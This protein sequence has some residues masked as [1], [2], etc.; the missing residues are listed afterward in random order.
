MHIG[1]FFETTTK[2]LKNVLSLSCFKAN[3]HKAA[4]KVSDAVRL[5]DFNQLAKMKS[6]S[7]D[8]KLIASLYGT[9]LHSVYRLSNGDLETLRFFLDI[10]IDLNERDRSGDTILDTAVIEGRLDICRLLVT[11]GIKLQAS[12]NSG[13]TTPI[14]KAIR[15][16]Q[17]Q[18]LVYFLKYLSNHEHLRPILTDILKEALVDNRI[19]LINLILSY[20]LD[21]NRTYQNK[22]NLIHFVKSPY[23]FNKL[24]DKGFDLNQQDEFGVSFIAKLVTDNREELACAVLECDPKLEDSVSEFSDLLITAAKNNNIK[25]LEELIVK[26]PGAL[27]KLEEG[28][29]FNDW[30]ICNCVEDRCSLEVIKFFIDQ[31]ARIDG[32]T[33][34]QETPLM[35]AAQK[36]NPYYMRYLTKAGANPNLVDIEGKNALM[37]TII[38]Q[39]EKCIMPLLASTTNLFAKDKK[40]FDIILHCAVNGTELVAKFLMAKGIGLKKTCS[41]KQ[42]TLILAAMANN[43]D[44]ISFLVQLGAD[45]DAVDDQQRSALMY[46][47]NNACIESV[48]LLLNLGAN[49]TLVDI[50]RQSA[51]DLASDQIVKN[52]FNVDTNVIETEISS[53]KIT[54]IPRSKSQPEAT[55]LHS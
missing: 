20:D 50:N 5:G 42:T 16:D 24:V 31:G 33:H 23:V 28:L 52:M 11:H 46:A 14:Q 54:A 25:L 44:M 12:D 15:Y 26:Q 1:K 3:S 10:G 32:R 39:S 18:I 9:R 21:V 29:T 27:S 2:Q 45:V 6:K 35:I 41:N 55:E 36:N 4:L 37:H 53:S 17:E 22:C 8:F 51:F 38:K 7:C 48:E 19:E 43:V 13:F 40:G 47:S 34:R 30:I 49:K